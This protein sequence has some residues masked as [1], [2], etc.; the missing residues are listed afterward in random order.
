MTDINT[1]TKV[2][3]LEEQVQQLLHKITQ[4]ENLPATLTALG[5][6]DNLLNR[7]DKLPFNLENLDCSVNNELT[8]LNNLPSSL[9]ILDCSFNEI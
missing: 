5:C 9:E 3:K 2:T 4:L 1:D 8:D 7:L 6:S